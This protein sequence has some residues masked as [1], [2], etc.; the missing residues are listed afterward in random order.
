MKSHPGFEGKT[1]RQVYFVRIDLESGPFLANT[2]DRNITV[3][4]DLYY[5]VGQLGKIGEFTTTSGTT[6]TALKFTLTNIPSSMTGE[7]ANENTRNKPVK[8]AIALLDQHNQ[9]AADLIWWFSGTIDSLSMDI[10]QTVSVAA[11][12][13]SR[14]INWARSVNSRYTNEDQQSKYPG[15]KGFFFIADM[16]NIKLQWG[17]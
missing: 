4:G 1:I 14:L 11:S 16:M 7:V 10:G 3:G 8:V 15:D 13:S 6:A 5:G 17:S 9:L 2:S 12:A